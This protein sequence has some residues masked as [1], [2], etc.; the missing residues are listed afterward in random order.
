M[1]SVYFGN[2][3]NQ[4]WIKAPRTGMNAPTVGWSNQ[5]TLLSGK[6]FVKRSTASHRRFDMSW[7][8]SRNDPDQERSLQTIKDLSLIHI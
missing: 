8:G 1:S 2:A 5:G 3:N 4:T 6:A 7:L